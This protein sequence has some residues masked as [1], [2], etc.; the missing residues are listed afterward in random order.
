MFQVITNGL[1]R[2]CEW[3]TKL[4]CLNLL[5]IMFT[6]VGLGLFGLFPSTTAMFTVTKK[7]LAQREDIQLF[8]TFYKT[9]K[10]EFWRSNGLGLIIIGISF[11]FYVDFKILTMMTE[12]AIY[13]G[14]PLLCLLM[15]CSVMLLYLFP[16]YVHYKGTY[17]QLFKN[18]FL[19][20]LS[21]PIHTITL[22]TGVFGL[23][24]IV[25]YHITILLFFSGS[26]LAL[27]MTA[28]CQKAFHSIDLIKSKYQHVS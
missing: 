18:A 11:V 9:F 10:K 17:L 6:F 14:I 23:S 15:I 22:I 27:V 24:Y 7:W 28:L 4:A 2:F 3:V 19:I 20:S 1:Y 5:W 16:V 25:F 21:K 13:I 26:L 12:D 8:K